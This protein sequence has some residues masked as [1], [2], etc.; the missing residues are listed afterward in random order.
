MISGVS[1]GAGVLR[2]IRCTMPRCHP[3]TEKLMSR[4]P[5]DSLHALLHEAEAELSRRLHEAC[6]AEAKGIATES[7]EE[8]RRLEDTLL[9][10]AFAAERT[11]AAR[12]HLRAE[13]QRAMETS[14]EPS[15]TRER[16]SV[17]SPKPDTTADRSAPGSTSVREFSDK[18]GRSWR[19]WPVTPDVAHARTASRRSLGDFQEGWIC[20]EALDDSGRRRLPRR[21]RRWSD[22]PAEELPRLLE[23]AITVPVRKPT[24]HQG[25]SRADVGKIS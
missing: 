16:A 25:Q 11:I 12:R 23:E 13:S 5:T 19:A 3:I 20:F 15:E 7:A 18:H 24:Q 17:D 2:H 1:T 14:A 21:G 4:R 9:S 10:A 8:I 22:L 6:E